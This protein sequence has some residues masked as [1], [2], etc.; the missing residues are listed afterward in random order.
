[1]GKTI[2][3]FQIIVFGIM[4]IVTAFVFLFS[5]G[6]SDGNLPGSPLVCRSSGGKQITAAEL[7]KHLKN[8]FQNHANDFINAAVKNKIDVI[9]LV[10]IAQHETGYGASKAVREKNNPGGIMDP[11]T[12]MQSVRHFPT[13][14]EGIDYMAR[15]LY[16]NYISKGLTT[17]Q[18]IG[19]KYAPV[20]A[21]NDPNNLNRFWIPTVTKIANEMGGVSGNCQLTGGIQSG[22]ISGHGFQHPIKNPVL[23]SSF[24]PR[25]GKLHK[26]ID[27]AHPTG[28]EILAASA[29]T[30]Q[31]ARFG[32]SGSGFGGYGNVVVINH[33]NGYW[34]LYGHMSK[35][36]V[37]EGDQV[38][39]GQVIGL[40]GNTGRSI[41]PHL[42]FEIK[43]SYIFGQIDPESMLPPI[44]NR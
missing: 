43:T 20:G 26:G 16:K 34:T 8:A 10:A 32:A 33:N 30:V 23:S 29:G 14:A 39:R 17:I 9:L 15:N 42:H 27:L 22:P 7:N 35:I 21:S 37:R 31:F 11:S 19:Q 44:T 13:L 24:G 5:G 2:A 4:G 38:Q 6:S 18:Q 25:W 1:M 36:T 12:N 28:T 41:G 40:V 3:Y